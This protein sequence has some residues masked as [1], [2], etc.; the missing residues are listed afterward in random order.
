MMTRKFKGFKVAYFALSLFVIIQLILRLYGFSFT[1]I[2]GNSWLFL[3]ILTFYIRFFRHLVILDLL[4]VII[5]L[6]FMTVTWSSLILIIIVTH[7]ISYYLK[8]RYF[9]LG[10]IR[11]II[12]SYYLWMISWII[13]NF[14]PMLPI[15]IANFEVQEQEIVIKVSSLFE[16]KYYYHESLNPFI[17]KSEVKDITSIKTFE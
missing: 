4:F 3:L 17:M 5:G 14:F 16:D 7:I 12:C 2:L 6:H 13:F 8:E 9:I 11:S 10:W 1:P 15:P